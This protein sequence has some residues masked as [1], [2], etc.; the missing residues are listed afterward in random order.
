MVPWP[1]GVYLGLISVDLILTTME[2]EF[3]RGGYVVASLW[4]REEV[5]AKGELCP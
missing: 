4:P 5:E 3:F 1:R 2:S